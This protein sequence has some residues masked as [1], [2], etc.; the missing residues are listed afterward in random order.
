MPD[1]ISRNADFAP[2]I[3][4]AHKGSVAI[5]ALL[6]IAHIGAAARHG[7][8]LRDGLALRMLSIGRRSK[9]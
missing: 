8:I 6:S 4:G 3:R 7:F 9:E 5:L 1:L 2:Y